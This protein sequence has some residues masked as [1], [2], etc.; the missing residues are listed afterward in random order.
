M[1]EV[2]LNQAELAFHDVTFE[3]A[4]TLILW[5]LG[6]VLPVDPL[7]PEVEVNPENNP[8]LPEDQGQLSIVFIC[9]FNFGS[10]AI[11]V[12]DQT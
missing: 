10:Q 9:S 12:Y 3:S 8:L 1:S 7:D 5:N 11:S 6:L 4:I 2:S